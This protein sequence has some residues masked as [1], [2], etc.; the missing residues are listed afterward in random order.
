ML[1]AAR[2][3]NEYITENQWLMKTIDHNKRQMINEI[4]QMMKPN[5]Y[6]E[7]H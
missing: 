4:Q 3:P 1:N 7:N 5:V 6:N 2:K